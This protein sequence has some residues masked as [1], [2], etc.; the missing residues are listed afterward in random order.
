MALTAALLATLAA[1]LFTGAAVYITFVE[2][3]ARVSCG[4]ALAV[5]EFG[6]I[7]AGDCDAGVARPRRC[8]RGDRP[9]GSRR[10]ARLDHRRHGARYR[11][12]V[13]AGRPSPDEPSSPGRLVGQGVARGRGAT[14]SMVP[15]PRRSERPEPRGVR[16]VPHP[17]GEGR[18]VTPGIADK[19]VRPQD[20]Y[21]RSLSPAAPISR[22][23]EAQQ[24][25]LPCASTPCPRTMHPQCSQRG[26]SL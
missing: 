6:P 15:A 26:A 12:A 3:P 18:P 16:L 23:H 17:A 25:N 24:K 14:R 8:E 1:G 2:H 22:A 9:M 5:T 20:F 19:V 10:R 13:H 7:Q 4:S 11:G 21:A